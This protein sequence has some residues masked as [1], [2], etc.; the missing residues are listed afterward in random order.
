MDRYITVCVAWPYANNNLH[1]GHVAGV[2]S[3]DILAR[4]HR[5]QGDHVLMVGGTDS[6]GTKPS[7]RAKKEG[8]T[9]KDIVDRYHKNFKESFDKFNF[10]YDLYSITYD[11]Y[12]KDKVKEFTKKFYNNGYLYE[13]SVIRPYCPTCGKFVADTEIEITCP[14]CGRRTKADS[15]DCGHVP[16]EKDLEGATCL[17]CG[18][19]TQQK[20]NKVLVFKLSAFKKE[21]EAHLKNNEGKWR[22]NSINETQKYLKDLQDRDFSRDLDWGIEIP[23]AGFEDKKIWVWWEALLGYVTDTMRLCEERNLNFDDYW[24]NTTNTQKRIYLCHAKDNIPFH[25]LFLPA[26]LM[27]TKEDYFLPDVMV[28]SE[29]L[30][31]NDAKISKSA[32]NAMSAIDYANEYSTDSLRYYLIAYGPE[33][34]DTNFTLELFASVHNAD[35]V[36]KF[37][38][39]INRVLKFK[40][41]ETLPAGKVDEGL[42]KQVADAYKNGATLIESLEF[43]KYADIVMELVANTNKFYDEQKPWALAKENIEAFNDVIYTCA[44]VIAN[45]SNLLEPIM[46]D[47]CAKLRKYLKLDAK[48]CFKPIDVQSGIDLSSVAPLFDR[49][50]L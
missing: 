16:S 24:K 43:K 4:Y 39:L 47:A 23:I 46:P 7:I 30:T 6:H 17:V 28:S 9:P 37:G 3:S 15:C 11:Q 33:K 32:G 5:M 35:V 8:V 49:I 2:I 36:N 22:Q 44:Y 13:N 38:N 34:R 26:M 45:L 18:G 20:E 21:L 48:P 29:Y 31:M 19:T 12:H 10:S 42:K 1:L 41:L 25:S 14:V 50:K 40:G 27:A